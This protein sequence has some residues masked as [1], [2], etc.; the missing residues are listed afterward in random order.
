MNIFCLSISAAEGLHQERDELAVKSLSVKCGGDV[1]RPS[2]QRAEL[3]NYAVYKTLDPVLPTAPGI[4][5]RGGK[6]NPH[7]QFR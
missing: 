7:L 4:N 5:T 3:R 1:A 6:S 2:W